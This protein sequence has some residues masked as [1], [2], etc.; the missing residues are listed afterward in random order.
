VTRGAV[1]AG[2]VPHD[3]RHLGGPGRAGGHDRGISRVP[4]APAARLGVCRSLR[5]QAVTLV[6]GVPAQ[7]HVPHERVVPRR[8]AVMPVLAA[9]TPGALTAGQVRRPPGRRVTPWP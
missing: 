3:S 5:G 4:P 8:G 6:T 2:R 9:I 7:L 1:L